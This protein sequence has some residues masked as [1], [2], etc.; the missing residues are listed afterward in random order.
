MILSTS[1]YC[2]PIAYI[3]ATC[4]VCAQCCSGGVPMSGNVGLPA[5]DAG[6]WQ[7]ATNYDINRLRTLKDNRRILTDR[8][9]ERL[10]KSWLFQGGYSFSKRWAVDAFLS[11]VR[12]ERT[13]RQANFPEDFTFS[14]GV[15]DATLL[16]K[17]QLATFHKQRSNW[18]VGVGPKIPLGA[19]D[20]QDERGITLVA[21]L[22]PGS[23]AWDAVFWSEFA[24]QP[25]FRP[26]ISFSSRL[27]YRMTGR[28]DDYLSTQV[29]EFGDEMQLMTSVSDRVLLGTLIMNPGLTLRYRKAWEDRTND[30]TVPNSGGDFLFVTPGVS[31]QLVPDLALQTRLDIPLFRRVIGTQLVPDFRWNIGVFFRLTGSARTE[32]VPQLFETK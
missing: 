3:L 21:D 30:E 1:K 11:Y 19:A 20:R 28:N 10:T 14:Q 24:H 6:V 17:Y 32:T 22:Q 31:L 26:S 29:Y 18:W 2:L 8:S 27:I 13:I 23:G 9:R 5:T 12:Q 15:G 4:S 25:F 16:L 7:F